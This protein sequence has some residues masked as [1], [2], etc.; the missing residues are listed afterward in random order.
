[1][2]NGSLCTIID[3]VYKKTKGDIKLKKPA[4]KINCAH[5]KS[6]QISPS[7]RDPRAHETEPCTPIFLVCAFTE[8][9]GPSYLLTN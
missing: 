9:N 6:N 5:Y 1:M 8:F 3:I 2:N 7:D 4:V